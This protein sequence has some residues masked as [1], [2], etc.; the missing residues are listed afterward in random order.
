MWIFR[1]IKPRRKNSV[2]PIKGGRMISGCTFITPRKEPG[3]CRTPGSWRW[4]SPAFR[5]SG[6][7]C[8]PTRL[9]WPA[10]GTGTCATQMR[11]AV[12][13]R[14]KWPGLYAWG[15]AFLYSNRHDVPCPGRPSKEP[16]LR[17]GTVMPV[18]ENGVIAKFPRPSPVALQGA[19][20]GSS[21]SLAK[22]EDMPSISPEARRANTPRRRE[23]KRCPDSVTNLYRRTPHT[24]N[25]QNSLL[26]VLSLCGRA[27]P[28]QLRTGEFRLRNRC[29]RDSSSNGVRC[30]VL[31]LLVL[32]FH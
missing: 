6:A 14:S 17:K 1:S 4:N 15:K 20:T 7:A 13:S 9:I 32:T 2:T 21:M 26:I 27:T 10:S 19:F 18:P 24:S 31:G 16:P 23:I 29:N 25:S 5:Y 8:F 30:N 11:S 12:Q 28:H 3:W 22:A